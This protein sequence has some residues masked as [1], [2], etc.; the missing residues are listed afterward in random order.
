MVNL[1]K[2]LTAQVKKKS[3][4]LWKWAEVVVEAAAEA[5]SVL[6]LRCVVA[7]AVV[8]V[9]AEAFSVPHLRWWLI[10]WALLWVHQ[11]NNRCLRNKWWWTVLHLRCNRWVWKNKER[12]REVRCKVPPWRCKR[13]MG[14]WWWKRRCQCKCK[15]NQWGLLHRKRQSPRLRATSAAR[16]VLT[17]M[18]RQPF[19]KWA[20]TDESNLNLN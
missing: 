12:H 13:M 4:K 20:S 6:G 9:A 2:L 1:A 10:I 17:T 8:V 7:E 18:C 3:I 14:T 16:S 11:C 15:H 5:F 19:S